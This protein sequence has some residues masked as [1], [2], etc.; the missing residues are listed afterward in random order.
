[1]VKNLSYSISSGSSVSS[2]CNFSVLYNLKVKPEPS[3]NFSAPAQMDLK[4]FGSGTGFGSILKSIDPG[5]FGT[6]SRSATLTRTHAMRCDTTTYTS[7][8]CYHRIV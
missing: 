7:V 6:S 4:N 2:C 8:Y 5:G 3:F 1:M